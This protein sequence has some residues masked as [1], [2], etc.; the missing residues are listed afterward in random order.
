MRRIPGRLMVLCAMLAGVLAIGATAAQASGTGAKFKPDTS[1]SVVVGGPTNGAL[2]IFIDESGVGQLQVNYTLDWTATADYGCINGGGNH[3]QATNKATTSA[4][5]AASFS[6]SPINGRVMATFVVP[7]TPPPA[8]S[9]FS[10]PS[11]QTLVLADVSYSATLTDTTNNSSIMLSAS[12][13]F[14]TFKK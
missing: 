12:H 14:F 5:A 10:C 9:G 2:S 11:G 8:P 3:P 7:D 4:G 1:A 13:T 6:E